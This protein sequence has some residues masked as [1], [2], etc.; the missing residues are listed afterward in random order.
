MLIEQRDRGQLIEHH[1]D[2]RST[3]R[4]LDGRKLVEFRRSQGSPNSRGRE[5][6]GG[7]GQHTQREECNE[8]PNDPSR[9]QPSEQPGARTGG[10]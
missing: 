3:S 2:D 5:E 7:K 4:H 1:Q 10:G 8:I 6:N 9:G